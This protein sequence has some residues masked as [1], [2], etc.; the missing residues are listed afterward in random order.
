MVMTE[1]TK[2]IGKDLWNF[3]NK[4]IKTYSSI[5]FGKL[6]AALC[7]FPVLETKYI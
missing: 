1:C 6:L 3:V 2:A 7:V 4:N 5:D